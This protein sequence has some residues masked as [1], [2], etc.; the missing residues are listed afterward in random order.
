M[1]NIA[2]DLTTLVETG[3][4]SNKKNVK[5]L[6]PCSLPYKEVLIVMLEDQ[7]KSENLKM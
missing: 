2:N 4:N 6:W 1:Y 3:G 5:L 7:P